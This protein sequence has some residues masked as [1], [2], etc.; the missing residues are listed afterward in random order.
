MRGKYAHIEFGSKEG[1][2]FVSPFQG[3]QFLVREADLDGLID[4]LVMFQRENAHDKQRRVAS[5]AL[6]KKQETPPMY[7]SFH[8]R[9]EYLRHED[10]ISWARGSTRR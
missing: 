6:R 2:I 1:Y 4:D 9:P 3:T 8:E 5:A 10:I 7:F